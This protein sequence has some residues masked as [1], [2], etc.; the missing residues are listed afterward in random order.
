MEGSQNKQFEIFK[1]ILVLA[2]IYMIIKLLNKWGLLGTSPDD[3]GAEQLRTSDVF[4]PS[5][6]VD[7]KIV[8]A[9]AKATGKGAPSIN[10]FKKIV[11]NQKYFPE[12]AKIILTAKGVTGDNEAAIYGVFNNMYSQFEAK[13]FADM[14]ALSLKKNNL[15]TDLWSF[16]D[17]FLDS[18]EMSRINTIIKSKK[19]A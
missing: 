5:S 4:N 18:G 9:A 13:M 3:K 7:N 17:E 11:P 15:G 12:W 6:S 8:V 19:L 1:W 14:F 2:A 10:D 16:L